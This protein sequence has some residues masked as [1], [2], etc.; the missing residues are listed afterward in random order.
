VSLVH[1]AD[2]MQLSHAAPPLS[3]RRHNASVNSTLL[4]TPGGINRPRPG[5]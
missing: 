4:Y 3:T 2:L 5:N 1:F